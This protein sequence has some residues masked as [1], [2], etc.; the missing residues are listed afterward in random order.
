MSNHLKAA[1]KKTKYDATTQV[2]EVE[3]A[4]TAK[5]I[6]SAG[7][8]SIKKADLFA[9]ESSTLNI[10]EKLKS[11]TSELEKN[12]SFEPGDILKLKDKEIK[13]QMEG[14][15][16]LLEGRR[17]QTV[18]GQNMVQDLDST[19]NLP[20]NIIVFLE[21]VTKSG[22]EAKV[23]PWEYFRKKIMEIYK[24]RIR[25]RTE[26]ENSLINTFIPFSEYICLYF[27]KVS[28]SKSAFD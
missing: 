26:V 17:R 16:V 8:D 25:N 12:P 27:L 18:M 6:Q 7:G 5:N 1:L 23:L 28:H 21:N 11:K 24:D 14:K 9:I 20:L 19:W 3:L 4:W 22:A 2:D 13:E 10:E 15:S